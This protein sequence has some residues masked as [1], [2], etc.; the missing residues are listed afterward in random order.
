MST[1]KIYKT[2]LYYLY[3][4]VFDAGEYWWLRQKL[5]LEQCTLEE[6]IKLATLVKNCD[7]CCISCWIK[8]FSFSVVCFF[9]Q[10][11]EVCITYTDTCYIIFENFTKLAFSQEILTGTW[12]LLQSLFTCPVWPAETSIILSSATLVD[13]DQL[14]Q[15]SIGR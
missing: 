2:L 11:S 12:A 13:N 14:D 5:L 8:V 10:L 1:Y 15:Y 4:Y 6:A 9:V 7:L 3:N